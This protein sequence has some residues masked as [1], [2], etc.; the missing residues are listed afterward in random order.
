MHLIPNFNEFL[1]VLRDI[2]DY[3]QNM[4]VKVEL[5]IE[6]YLGK[7]SDICT[8]GKSSIYIDSIG[9]VYPCAFSERKLVLGNI[10]KDTKENIKEKIYSFNHNNF[11]CDNCMIH[12]YE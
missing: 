12:R 3:S 5:P 6:K 1:Q 11:I 9:D 4:G 8:L 10:I 7:K 2:R